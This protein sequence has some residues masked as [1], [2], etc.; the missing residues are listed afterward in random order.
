MKRR[1]ALIFAILFA[2][3]AGLALAEAPAEDVQAAAAAPD[4]ETLV[5][6]STTAM[7]GNFLSDMW[8]S[9][10][11]DMDVRTLLHGYNPVEWNSALGNYGIDDSVVSGLVVTD[12]P[13][14][15]R[16]YT[17]A[18]YDD[19]LYCDGTP[20]TARD[21]VFSLLLSIAPEAAEIGGAVNGGAHILGVEDY[22]SG[23][24]RGLAGL[25]LLGEHQFSLTVKA[26]Y[27]PFFYEMALLDCNPYPIGVIAPGCEVADEGEGAFIR[28]I[29][30]EADA[31]GEEPT[32]GE[33]PVEGEEPADDAEEEPIFTA[34]LLRETIL[35][36]ETGYLTHPAITSGPYKLVSYDAESSV[37]EFEINEY[38]KGN[39]AGQKPQIAHLVFKQVKNEDAVAQLESGELGLMNKCVNV[40]TLDAGMQLVTGGKIAVSNY[41]R[42]GYSFISFNCERPAIQSEAVRHAVALCFDKDAFIEAY[43]RNYGMR[44]DGYYG[45]GQWMYRLV[46]GTQEAAVQE[47]AADADEATIKAYEREKAAWDA[48]NL[49][50]VEKYDLDIA[51]A[52]QTLV[53][54]GW[55]L[56]RD[57][58]DFEPES[59]DVRCKMIDDELVAL[60]L[61]L[62]YPEGNAVGDMLKETFV[63]NLKAAGVALEVESLPFA[64]L[65]KVYYRQTER[66]CDMIYLATNFASVFEPSRTFAPDDAYQG[67]DNR[68]GV[69]DEQL[70]ALAVDMRRT[71][72][73]DTLSYC[74]K[75][76]K[77]QE[78]WAEVL[79]AIPVY[80]NVYFDFYAP[81]LHNYSV[82]ANTGWADAIVGAYLSDADEPAE[83]V[84]GNPEGEVAEFID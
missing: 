23:E 42:S 18:I 16:T 6:G 65:L 22:L 57:G 77:F 74:Q 14:G 44:V 1:F 46:S 84:A 82:G 55:T 29:A 4:Y 72:P 34:E 52:V 60:E 75:W 7:S 36:A 51:A 15:N 70:Y 69:A 56:N 43:V 66:D 47:P 28:N 76:V 21:Y 63:E 9:N 54:D 10:T 64:E 45:V 61:K 25:R 39:S 5:V 31:E 68:T 38:Y 71:E 24:S 33:E 13:A 8:G 49:T 62:V 73:G 50:G 19:L 35:N 3:S 79:P 78:R 26:E 12:D 37:A 81:A 67:V 27:L 53:K 2:L 48:L 20:I 30:D 58:K 80:S 83:D 59:D 11:A 40:D 41:T 17:V 32:E